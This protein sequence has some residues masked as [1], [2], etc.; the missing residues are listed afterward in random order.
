MVYFN[1]NV[2]LDWTCGGNH[3]AFDSKLKLAVQKQQQYIGQIKIVLKGHKTN[4]VHDV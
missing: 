4:K 3:R 1:D 2:K